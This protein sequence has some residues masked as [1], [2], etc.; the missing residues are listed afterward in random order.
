[1]RLRFKSTTA[2]NGKLCLPLSFTK[3]LFRGE[4]RTARG[5]E[6]NIPWDFQWF[7]SSPN[8]SRYWSIGNHQTPHDILSVLSED[9]DKIQE[10]QLPF[11]RDSL[12]RWVITCHNT[13]NKP[14]FRGQHRSSRGMETNI[15]WGFQWFPSSPNPSRYFIGNHQAPHSPNRSR[16]FIGSI[17]GHPEDPRVTAYPLPNN[18]S[19]PSSSESGSSIHF[20]SSRR[21]GGKSFITCGFR[22]HVCGCSHVRTINMF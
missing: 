11:S 2:G 5:M 21:G 16:Y 7:P 8:P 13:F 19:F 18:V 14:L 3:P 10:S 12:H 9:I 4:H 17:G 15:P 22:V 20:K 6:T 1:M